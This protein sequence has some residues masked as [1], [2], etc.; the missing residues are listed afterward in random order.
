[1]SIANVEFS[2]NG[3]TAPGYLARPANPNGKAVIVLQEWW[4]LMPEIAA[5]CDRFAEDGFFALA[6]DLYRGEATELPDEAQQKM[7]ALNMQQ[8][9][10]DLRG[11]IDFV[12]NVAGAETV[13]VIGFCLGGGLS[14]FAASLNPKVGACSSFYYVM[15]HQQPDFSKISAPVLMHFA[16]EDAFIPVEQANALVDEMRAAG[17]NVT[18]EFYDGCG[19]AFFNASNRLGTYDAAAADLAWQRTAELFS[20]NL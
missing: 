1:M 10:Q 19:H 3:G 13:G 16:S 9:E 8:T 12:A 2:A 7:M 6:P 15:P 14:V 5:V 18:A 20:Q 4:G 17:A 11:A